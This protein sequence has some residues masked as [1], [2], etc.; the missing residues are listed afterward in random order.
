MKKSRNQKRFVSVNFLISPGER[1]ILKHDCK[2][3]GVNMSHY[4]RNQIFNPKMLHINQS[5]LLVELANIG[6]QMG[7][8]NAELSKAR[9]DRLLSAQNSGSFEEIIRTYTHLQENLESLFRNLLSR[10]RRRE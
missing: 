5:A 2:M 4:I 3:A 10:I 8:V 1:E 6:T 7:K 9:T